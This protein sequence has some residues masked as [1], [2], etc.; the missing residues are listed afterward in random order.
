MLIHTRKSILRSI[1]PQGKIQGWIISSSNYPLLVVPAG[2][3]IVVFHVRK[4]L[5]GRKKKFYTVSFLTIL[6]CLAGVIRDVHFM[7]YLISNF[8][9]KS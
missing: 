5:E 6:P 7:S 2:T 1:V 9:L 4:F 8:D 3:S